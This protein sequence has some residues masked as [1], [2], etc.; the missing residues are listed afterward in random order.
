[1]LKRPEVK[2][3]DLLELLPAKINE[4]NRFAG[5]TSKDVL[6]GIEIEVKYSGF[7]KRQFAEVRDFKHLEKIRIPSDLNYT[8]IPSLSAEIREKLLRFK[9]INLG[10]ASRISGITPV[11]ITILMV[12]LKKKH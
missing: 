2:I 5:F 1:L 6:R 7:I 9:P 10:Q 8:K 12:Y 11:A 4:I 3:K